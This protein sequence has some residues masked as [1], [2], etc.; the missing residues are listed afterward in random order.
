MMSFRMLR[1]EFNLAQNGR[2]CASVVVDQK[3]R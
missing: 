2:C 3:I 1:K